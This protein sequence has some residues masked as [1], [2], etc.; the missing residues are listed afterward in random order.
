M[1]ASLGNLGE[2]SVGQPVVGSSIGVFERWTN[3]ALDVRHFHRSS[4]KGTRREDSLP[5]DPEGYV[6][7]ALEL[8]IS[9]HR[10]PD[11]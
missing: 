3:G 11:G 1:G 7:K 9:P 5:G 8:G 2:D 10:G 4:V 6:E